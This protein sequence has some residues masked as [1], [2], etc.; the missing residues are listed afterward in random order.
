MP[1]SVEEK[2]HF[3]VWRNFKKLDFVLIPHHVQELN[4]S[5][6]EHVPSDRKWCQAEPRSWS[7]LTS[8]S[9]RW[10]DKKKAQPQTRP[11]V[12]NMFCTIF[13]STVPD[14]WPVCKFKKIKFF[15][16][17][18]CTKCNHIQLARH[19]SMWKLF[20]REEDSKLAIFSINKVK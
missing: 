16:N 6:E 8:E 7:G 5:G 18:Y 19:L 3:T 9:R 13:R 10:E 4:N 14:R 2:Q 15:S 11:D 12:M 17:D 1:V 20:L